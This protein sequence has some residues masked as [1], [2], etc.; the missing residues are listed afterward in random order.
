MNLDIFA[1]GV[2]IG[3][4][5]LIAFFLVMAVVIYFLIISAIAN[6]VNGPPKSKPPGGFPV[7]PN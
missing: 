1:P 3:A 5:L 2:L 7:K 4:L 6:K